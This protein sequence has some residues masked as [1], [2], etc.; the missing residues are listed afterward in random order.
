MF[1]R[2][3]YSR[4]I[5]AEIGDIDQRLRSLERHLERVGGRSVASAAQ[6]AE[7]VGE[8]IASTL[9]NVAERLRGGASSV[10]DEAAKIGGE[11]AKLGN[12]ALRRL[13]VEVEHRPLVTLAVA[14]GVGILVGLASHH[15]RRPTARPSR[16]SHRRH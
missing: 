1:H 4:A 9:N 7:Q 13:S 12:D 2:S 11:A 15:A 3:G 16:T 6:A 8:T 14:V 5:S 10:R